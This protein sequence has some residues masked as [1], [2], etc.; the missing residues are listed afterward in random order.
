MVA[1]ENLHHTY[2]ICLQCDNHLYAVRGTDHWFK[3]DEID[4]KTGQIYPYDEDAPEVK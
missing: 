4:I 3:C 1:T 2:Y